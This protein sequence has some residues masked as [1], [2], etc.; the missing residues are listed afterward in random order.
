MGNDFREFGDVVGECGG[1]ETGV[2][3]AEADSLKSVE[4]FQLGEEGVDIGLEVGDFDA[5]EDDFAVAVCNEAVHFAEDGG[6]WT[7]ARATSYSRDDAI[8]AMT[9]A[10][11]LDFDIG[12]GAF[13]TSNLH[14]FE[15]GRFN[16]SDSDLRSMCGL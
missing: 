9:I 2:E 11:V 12:F 16:W 14:G 10:A 7:R 15:G 6:D 3:R 13:A 4:P 5:E 8:G 1:E